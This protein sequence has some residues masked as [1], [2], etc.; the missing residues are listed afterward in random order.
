MCAIL[1]RMLSVV[2]RDYLAKIGLKIMAFINSYN[3]FGS[4]WFQSYL[5]QWNWGFP[6]CF[7]IFNMLGFIFI[8][9]PHDHRWLGSGSVSS[10]NSIVRWSKKGEM[11]PVLCSFLRV[12]KLSP[13]SPQQTS[14]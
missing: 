3:M 11:L 1:V 9:V 7:P 2:K 13:N 8:F 5:I 6:Y 14:P 12:N 10:Q 4:R